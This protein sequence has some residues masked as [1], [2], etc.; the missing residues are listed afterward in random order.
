MQVLPLVVDD[1][2]HNKAAPSGVTP[3]PVRRVCHRGF[4]SLSI[5]PFAQQAVD[6]RASMRA[7][8]DQTALF[9]FNRNTSAQRI[10]QSTLNRVAVISSG[11]K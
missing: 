6:I 1:I 7:E 9:K 8:I 10:E 2:A 4:G 11:D 3:S 5:Q